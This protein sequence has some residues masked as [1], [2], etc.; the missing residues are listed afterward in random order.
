MTNNLGLTMNRVKYAVM[1]NIHYN[2]YFTSPPCWL[3]FSPLLG[4]RT[5][6]M[7]TEYP[8]RVNLLI[9]E[10][11]ES[12]GAKYESHFEERANCAEKR[13]MIQTRVFFGLADLMVLL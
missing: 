7:E 3:P 9:S 11:E 13:I 4:S 2:S 1:L 5:V 10:L 6:V 12:I 8:D